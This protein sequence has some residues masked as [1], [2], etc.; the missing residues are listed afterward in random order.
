MASCMPE[1]GSAPS[2]E[3]TTEPLHTR[4]HKNKRVYKRLKRTPIRTQ[5]AGSAYCPFGVQRALL[6]ITLSLVDD[7]HV[8]TGALRRI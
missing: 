6:T 4:T 3:E 1:D 8:P 7:R 5:G 2:K